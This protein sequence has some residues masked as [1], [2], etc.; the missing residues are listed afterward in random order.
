MPRSVKKGPFV[1]MHLLKKVNNARETG[2]TKPI[3]THPSIHF[4]QHD[5]AQVGRILSNSY[6][7]WSCI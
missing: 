5:W 4:R 3:E 6:L 2:S 7:L 1:D